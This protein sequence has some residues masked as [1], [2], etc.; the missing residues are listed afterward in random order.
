[1]ATLAHAHTTH[2]SRKISDESMR[3]AVAAIPISL[4]VFFAT[5]LFT[6]GPAAQALGGDASR[7]VV[8][9]SADA[10]IIASILA[11]AVSVVVSLTGGRKLD[12]YSRRFEEPVAV[13]LFTAVGAAA[14]LLCT[15]AVFAVVVS[16]NPGLGTQAWAAAALL[17]WIP[18]TVAMGATRAVVAPAAESWLDFAIAVVTAVLAIGVVWWVAAGYA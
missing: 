11:V 5:A 15:A 16:A 1:M 3:R 2:S 6:L 7:L 14:G 4:V 13:A 17:V 8:W 12:V 10:V 18:V 9:G